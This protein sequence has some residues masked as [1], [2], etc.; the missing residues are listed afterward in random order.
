MPIARAV[1]ALLDGELEASGAV[2]ALM[3]RDPVAEG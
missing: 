3:G 2:A 1:V